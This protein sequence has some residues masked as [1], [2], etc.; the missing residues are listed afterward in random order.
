V[1]APRQRRALHEVAS[2]GHAA[3]IRT[4]RLPTEGRRPHGPRPHARRGPAMRRYR[5]LMPVALSSLLVDAPLRA[6]RSVPCSGVHTGP[7][8]ASNEVSPDRQVAQQ[9]GRAAS[10]MERVACGNTPWLTSL[11]PRGTEYAARSP[12]TSRTAIGA[13]IHVFILHTANRRACFSNRAALPVSPY[14]AR[15]AHPRA[16]V[17]PSPEASHRLQRVRRARRAPRQA[18]TQGAPCWSQLPERRISPCTQ[19][20]VCLYGVRGPIRSP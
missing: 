3:S 20:R 4:A 8:P 14:A 7:A 5:L 2:R 17:R 18:R 19:S 16:H 1:A 13:S 9:A 15:R 6:G 11:H 12:V 10:D